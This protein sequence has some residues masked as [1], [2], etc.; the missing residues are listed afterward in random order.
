MSSDLSSQQKYLLVKAVERNRYV[1]TL[2]NPGIN[3]RYTLHRF[4]S[5]RL[6]T[7]IM[8]SYIMCTTDLHSIHRVSGSVL[9]LSELHTCTDCA[10][11]MGP[12]I[13]LIAP[14]TLHL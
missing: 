6:H 11:K 12:A 5:H 4:H 10:L 1:Q 3:N 7:H 9:A 2:P 14:N 13:I 8:L